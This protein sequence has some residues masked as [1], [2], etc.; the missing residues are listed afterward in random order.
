VIDAGRRRENGLIGRRTQLRQQ[1][2]ASPEAP[3]EI[4]AP[5]DTYRLRSWGSSPVSAL[6]KPASAPRGSR[7]DHLSP[8]AQEAAHRA[9]KAH[10]GFDLD[11]LER[12]AGARL[13]QEHLAAQAAQPGMAVRPKGARAPEPEPTQAPRRMPMDPAAVPHLDLLLEY[14]EHRARARRGL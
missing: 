6:Q 12:V 8:E 1:W 9:L 7:W 4:E 11:A 5:E 14:A 10:T 13:D 3:R 2:E